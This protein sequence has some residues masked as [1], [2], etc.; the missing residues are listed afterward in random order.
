MH[1]EILNS[2]HEFSSSQ[3]RSFKNQDNQDTH[4]DDSKVEEK[5]VWL[6]SQYEEEKTFQDRYENLLDDVSYQSEGL[7]KIDTNP[8]HKVKEENSIQDHINDDEKNIQVP[9]ED[10]F[11]QF[12]VD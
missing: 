9:L 1:T 6:Q 3:T 7:D 8:E 4:S 10:L 5:F 11:E 2:N 12:L